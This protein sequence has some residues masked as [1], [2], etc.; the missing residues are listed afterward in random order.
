VLSLVA[1]GEVVH[2]STTSLPL[3]Y[4]HPGVTTIPL[5]GLPEV[6]TALVWVT[7]RETAAVRAFAQLAE[8]AAAGRVG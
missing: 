2:P 5:H 8:Q 3:Y 1:R 4:V 7:E 6:E